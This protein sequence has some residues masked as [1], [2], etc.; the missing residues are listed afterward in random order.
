VRRERVRAGGVELAVFHLDGGG[1]RGGP[2]LVWAHGWGQTHAA[3]LPLAE[4]MRA[5]AP[6]V[7]V[8]FPGFGESPLPPTPWGT[9]DYADAIA[10]WLA[11]LEPA[12]HI[13]IA[14]SFGCRVGLQLAARH[15]Q[16]VAGLFLVAA[17]GLPRQRSPIEQARLVA[18]RYSFR[19]M[20]SLTPEGPA[21]DRLRQRFG[22]ADYRQAGALRPILVKT[23]GEDLSES[24]RAVCCPAVLVYGDRDHETPPELGERLKHLIPESQL[25]VLRG[26]DHWNV[27]T[28]GRH[29]LLQRLGE[30]V[31]RLS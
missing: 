10:E 4:S 9:A 6:S 19:L 3:L 31:E 26:F 1:P 17:A 29:Q 24:A 7:M 2:L 5:A 22:S 8:D 28:E 30:F 18:R 20:R 16:T 11:P 13:W 25:Y 14:H 15:P 12:R 23:V 21:R 27:L